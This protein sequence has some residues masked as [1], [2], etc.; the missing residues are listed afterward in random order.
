MKKPTSTSHRVGYH[1]AFA[2]EAH[3]L[4]KSFTEGN[5]AA[6][7][8]E[9]RRCLQFVLESLYSSPSCIY[10]WEEPV[11]L[12]DVLDKATKNH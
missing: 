3:V 7:L 4:A 2:R 1:T 5:T 8:A 10:W 11:S 6:A 12:K 9:T